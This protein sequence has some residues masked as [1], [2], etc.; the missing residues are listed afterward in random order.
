MTKDHANLPFANWIHRFVFI[1][2]TPVH[3]FI[4]WHTIPLCICRSVCCFPK[5]YVSGVKSQA[6]FLPN[7]QFESNHKLT[8]HHMNF[9]LKTSVIHFFPV[10]VW[11][12]SIL[13]HPACGGWSFRETSSCKRGAYWNYSTNKMT[14]LDFQPILIDETTTW[15]TG[16]T[17]DTY[18]TNNFWF[19]S[20]YL[21][22]TISFPQA[23][24]N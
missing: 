6:L 24:P 13:W 2:L 19:Y 7:W 21:H 14:V 3:W 9:C 15:P 1:E 10:V 16:I 11:L 22:N 23:L 20:V 17:T 8:F 4:L 18:H 12:F 5:V